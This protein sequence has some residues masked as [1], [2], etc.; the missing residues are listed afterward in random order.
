ME[1]TY[2]LKSAQVSFGDEYGTDI[3]LASDDADSTETHISIVSGPNGTSKSRVLASIV[4]FLCKVRDG[5]D[6]YPQRQ[7]NTSETHGAIGGKFKEIV[8][9]RNKSYDWGDSGRSR[10]FLSSR[11]TRTDCSTKSSVPKNFR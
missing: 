10:R 1:N 7:Y 6:T 9:Y 3:S 2:L 5:K 11:H 8:R 4:N